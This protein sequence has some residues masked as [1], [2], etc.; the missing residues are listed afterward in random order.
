MLPPSR[1]TPKGRLSM[2]KP[3]PK[4]ATLNGSF[5]GG[6]FSLSRQ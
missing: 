4:L 6:R 3:A 2:G 5:I 1:A